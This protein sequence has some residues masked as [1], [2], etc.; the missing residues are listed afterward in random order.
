MIIRNKWTVR[1]VNSGLYFAGF[2]SDC[3]LLLDVLNSGVKTYKREKSAK[4][5]IVRIGK[6]ERR[7]FK[8]EYIKYADVPDVYRGPPIIKDSG[9][10]EVLDS[11]GKNICYLR[12]SGCF[13]VRCED[14]RL[15]GF[16]SDEA[17]AWIWYSNYRRDFGLRRIKQRK[18]E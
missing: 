14:G 17:A 5:A 13:A 10:W 2:G 18:G 8:P 6:S 4:M 1:E 11:F 7:K 3:V 9:G 16:G 12:K 15:R